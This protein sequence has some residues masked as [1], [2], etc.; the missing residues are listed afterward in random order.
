[1]NYTGL[2]PAGG[3]ATGPHAPRQTGAKPFQGLGRERAQPNTRLPPLVAADSFTAWRM[4]ACEGSRLHITPTLRAPCF[5]D[6]RSLDNPRIAVYNVVGQ[7]W[8][9]CPALIKVRA[10]RLIADA[11]LG[12]VDNGRSGFAV[13]SRRSRRDALAVATD[14]SRMTGCQGSMAVPGGEPLFCP[15]RDTGAR[16]CMTAGVGA[17]SFSSAFVREVQG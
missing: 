16:A 8:D 4:L 10:R 12:R 13:V 9:S 6:Y 7:C 5:E 3:P 17:V 11:E 2:G 15:M 14:G 1:M